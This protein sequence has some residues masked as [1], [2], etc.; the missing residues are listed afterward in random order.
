MD[1]HGIGSPTPEPDDRH[2]FNAILAGGG[3]DEAELERDAT[4]ADQDPEPKTPA[5]PEQAEQADADP[6]DSPLLPVVGLLSILAHG[7]DVPTID[8]VRDALGLDAARAERLLELWIASAKPEGPAALTGAAAAQPDP[9]SSSSVAESAE[10]QPAEPRP[11]PQPEKQAPVVDVPAPAPAVQAPA[12][13][14][15]QPDPKPAQ[16]KAP[17]RTVRAAL[18]DWIDR[19]AQA[20]AKKAEPENSE[21]TTGAFAAVS[22]LTGVVTLLA[23]FLSFSM[24]LTAAQ[25]YGW[26]EN[27]AK[28]FPIIIDVGA[29]GGTFMG[30]ISA[31]RVYRTIGHQVL[32]VTLAASVLFNLVGHDLKGRGAVAALPERWH[33]TGKI[34]AVLIP[35]LLAYFVHAFSKAL[36]TF[37]DQRRAS[38]AAALAAELV[39]EQQAAAQR[40]AEAQRQ[41]DARRQAE[42]ERVAAA[43]RAAAQAAAPAAPAATQVVPVAKPSTAKPASKGKA[44]RAATIADA[45]A[46][47]VPGKVQYAKEISEA[48]V[49][50]GFNPPHRNSAQNWSQRLRDEHANTK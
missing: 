31:N 27:L 13:P 29:I 49:A 15:Q 39:A 37:T 17:T 23:F 10:P 48:L 47:F 35:M 19:R 38:K 14:E 7:G 8:S 32:V 30:A 21:I 4:A 26:D 44:G 1:A 18:V 33:W 28:L 42:A 24:M 45:R 22:I 41:A 50:A 6:D 43:Q 20:Q 34:A 9:V 25:H 5:E 11:E 46:V 36:K 40:K 12:E 2:L 16:D 3:V